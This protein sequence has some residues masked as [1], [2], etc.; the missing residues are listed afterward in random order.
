MFDLDIDK[1]DDGIDFGIRLFNQGK[2]DKEH[3]RT[4]IRNT[5]LR[6][7]I[8]NSKER[9]I[10]LKALAF[11]IYHEKSIKKL[12][13]SSGINDKLPLVITP[14]RSFT[15]LFYAA[16]ILNKLNDFSNEKGLF[17]IRS[18]ELDLYRSSHFD[19]DTIEQMILDLQDDEIANWSSPDF[20]TF[21]IVLK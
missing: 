13:Q 12:F 11:G 10:T 6:L 4:I 19:G 15:A 7:D 21:D 14:G 5:G 17:L 3:L 16:D 2:Y 20:H 9:E 1:I 8:T 18:I